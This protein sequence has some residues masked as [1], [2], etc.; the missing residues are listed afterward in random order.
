MKRK[1]DKEKAGVISLDIYRERLERQ[2]KKHMKKMLAGLTAEIYHLLETSV[3][4]SNIGLVVGIM[5]EKAE[6]VA[7]LYSKPGMAAQKKMKDPELYAKRLN[8]VK[9]ILESMKRVEEN[10]DE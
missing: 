2:Q 3:H 1:K 5:L 4:Y 8:R 10:E 7:Q 9:V 6:D